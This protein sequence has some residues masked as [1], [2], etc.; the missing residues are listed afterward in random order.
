MKEDLYSVLEKRDNNLRKIRAFTRLELICL[1]CALTVLLLVALPLLAN[2]SM[3]SNQTGCLNNL[4]QIGVGFQAWSNDH[5]DRRPWFVPMTEGG[6]AAHP[7]RNSASIHFAFIS[8]YVSP[9][10]LVDP[11]EIRG[12]KRVALNWTSGPGGFL[13]PA[14][15]DNALSHGVPDRAVRQ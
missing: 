4:R 10:V 7:F 14:F 9:T 13:N 11:V 12:T 3:R 1:I 15:A 2:P 8:N 6:S 5:D